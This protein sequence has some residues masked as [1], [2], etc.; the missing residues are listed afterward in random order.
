MKTNNK[1]KIRIFDKENNIRIYPDSGCTWLVSL[2]GQ[3][4]NN[5]GKQLDPE[6][7]K[8]ERFSGILD[9]NEKEIYE[10]DVVRITYKMD[11]CGD[12]ITDENC[13]VVFWD[14][15]FGEKMDSFWNWSFA[16]GF[17]IEVM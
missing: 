13:K 7:Y 1:F 3:I 9:K 16:P 2:D 11:D 12:L 17:T 10:N 5:Q 6:N 8:I 14:G 4:Y 15:A